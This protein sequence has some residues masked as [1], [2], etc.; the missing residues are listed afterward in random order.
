MNLIE[1][2]T[3]KI[4][5]LKRGEVRLQMPMLNAAVRER[6]AYAMNEPRFREFSTDRRTSPTGA[7]IVDAPQA[8]NRPRPRSILVA[9]CSMG[10]GAI[11]TFVYLGGHWDVSANRA[12]STSIEQVSTPGNVNRD[13]VALLPTQA[14]V[15]AIDARTEAI[16]LVGQWAAAWS[17]RDVE[18]YL[19]FYSKSFIPPDN[20]SLEA[21]ED[22]R[23]IRILG[24][25]RI[26]VTIGNLNVEL[27]D[28]NRAIAQFAQTYEADNYRESRATKILILARE[29][30][31]WRIAA[32]MNPRDAALQLAR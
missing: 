6:A 28:D 19:G 9:L 23:R 16:G 29:G 22:K 7:H 24:K 27:L 26:S 25:Q 15:P 18:R 13:K 2:A 31:E 8:G 12:S 1:N 11:M 14:L 30:N 4:D 20:S 21:W 5:S 17:Q 32:E 3:G 10:A